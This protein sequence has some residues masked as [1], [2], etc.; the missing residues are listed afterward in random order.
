MQVDAPPARPV[1]GTADEAEEADEDGVQFVGRNG[2]I[3]LV[4]FPHVRHRHVHP[5]A[6]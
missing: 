4:D 5:P 2:E 3:A 6:A 1:G